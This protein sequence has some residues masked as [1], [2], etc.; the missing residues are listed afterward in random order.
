MTFGLYILI[1]YSGCKVSLYNI[2]QFFS[3]AIRSLLLDIR[4]SNHPDLC[5]T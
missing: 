4:L 3:G 5:M 1:V 2:L